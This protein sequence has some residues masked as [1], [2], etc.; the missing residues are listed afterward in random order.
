MSWISFIPVRAGSKGVRNKNTYSICGKP[1][2]RY[3]VDAALEAGAKKVYISTDI[4]TILNKPPEDKITVIKRDSSLCQDNSKMSSVML[5]FL[6]NG[7]GNGIIDDEIIVLMQ[8]T[9]PLRE[10]FDLLQALNQYSQSTHVELLL[11]VTEAENHALKYG[12]VSDGNFHHLSSP[13]FCFENRQN[14]PKL[15]RPT[16]AFYIFQAGWY[17]KN[18]NFTTTGT[19]AYQ[20]SSENSLDIDSLEDIKHVEN[21][22]N[23]K[24]KKIENCR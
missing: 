8:A 22:I 7:V 13:H 23:K 24:R 19:G 6:V 21:V 1:L 4:D 14:L 2:Y 12:Y 17:R 9:S 10:K 16:G 20:I 18:K 3:T 5:D 15:F 11:S